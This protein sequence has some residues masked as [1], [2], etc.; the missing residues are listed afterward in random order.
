MQTARCVWLTSVLDLLNLR[1][2]KK[3]SELSTSMGTD[4]NPVGAWLASDANG[5]V[6]LVNRSDAIASKLAPTEY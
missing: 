1:Q 2:F 4:S 5:A 3:L 6:C